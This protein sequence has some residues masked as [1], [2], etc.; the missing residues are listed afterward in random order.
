LNSPQDAKSQ[1][2]F[3]PLRELFEWCTY[4]PRERT[5]DFGGCRCGLLLCYSRV[6][7]EI[8]WVLRKK[9]RRI[10]STRCGPKMNCDLASCGELRRPSS[11]RKSK[12]YARS[13]TPSP[14]R[15]FRLL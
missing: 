12:R 8:R 9:F 7:E 4:P 1:F 14:F 2:I 11:T 3:G 13:T 6:D 15:F 10:W 5:A